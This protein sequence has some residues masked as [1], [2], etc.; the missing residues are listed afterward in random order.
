MC[1]Q[2]HRAVAVTG[3]ALNCTFWWFISTCTTAP[4]C[5]VKAILLLPRPSTS[6]WKHFLSKDDSNKKRKGKK[7]FNKHV[8]GPLGG[9]LWMKCEPAAPG[10]SW[11]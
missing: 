3:S 5:A 6:L 7:E 10:S 1:Q 4:R 8:L 11:Q 2:M 9:Q